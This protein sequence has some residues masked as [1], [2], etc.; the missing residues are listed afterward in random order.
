MQIKLCWRNLELITAW[1]TQFWL[2]LRKCQFKDRDLL[3]ILPFNLLLLLNLKK[4]EQKNCLHIIY[5]PFPQPFVIMFYEFTRP[6][7]F[8]QVA[9]V[10]G[11]TQPHLSVSSPSPYPL[12]CHCDS[13]WV[14]R[15]PDIQ[16]WCSGSLRP[17]SFKSTAAHR[18]QSAAAVTDWSFSWTNIAQRQ[19]MEI[20]LPNVWYQRTCSLAEYRVP[21]LQQNKQKQTTD[22]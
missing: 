5:L 15:S 12:K 11:N 19:R 2:D 10:T 9:L 20:W 13:I 8:Q 14:Q 18:Q 16:T 6:F 1:G 21:G 7:S 17:L 3:N 4:R 22:Y